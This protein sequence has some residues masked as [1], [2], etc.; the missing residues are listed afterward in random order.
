VVVIFTFTYTP[1]PTVTPVGGV[2]T[3]TPTAT[4]TATATRTPIPC[5][6]I[7]VYPNPYRPARAVGGTCKFSGLESSDRIKLF[8]ISG[9]KIF[10]KTGLNGRFDWDGT[11]ASGGKVA[12]GVYLW[13]IDCGDGEK[14]TG[15]LFLIR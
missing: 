14:F 9:E 7:Q 15:K 11:N 6:A 8:T 5:R 10:D 2:F 4:A 12:T 13:I 3:F 1:T